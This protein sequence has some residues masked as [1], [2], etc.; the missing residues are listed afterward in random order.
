MG[1]GGWAALTLRTKPEQR[2]SGDG[3]RGGKRCRGRVVESRSG[4]RE[5]PGGSRTGKCLEWWLF[6][7]FSYVNNLEFAWFLEF[8]HQV[9]S[10]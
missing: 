8:Q 4:Q 7:F 6:S 10:S 2:P 9:T 5:N 3:E 1:R